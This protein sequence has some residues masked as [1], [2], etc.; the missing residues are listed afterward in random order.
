MDLMSTNI[1]ITKLFYI[2]KSLLEILCEFFKKILLVGDSHQ[3]RIVI[4]LERLMAWFLTS[5][6]ILPFK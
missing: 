2:V 5:M 3:V 4:T 6:L 1:T